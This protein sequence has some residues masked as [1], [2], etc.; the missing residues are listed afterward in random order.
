MSR[1]LFGDIALGGSSRASGGIYGRQLSL[2]NTFVSS[3]H[4]SGTV[5]LRMLERLLPLIQ[6]SPDVPSD[7]V[8]GVPTP[9][10]TDRPIKQQ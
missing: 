1:S 8:I 5:G 2:L 10:V 7:D 9:M 4:S 3:D 6:C